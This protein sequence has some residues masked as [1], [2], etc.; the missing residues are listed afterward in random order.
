MIGPDQ[1]IET[2]LKTQQPHALQRRRREIE[3]GGA[4]AGKRRRNPFVADGLPAPVFLFER[5]DG[6]AIDGLQRRAGKLAPQE[7]G[8]KHLMARGHLAPCRPRRSA[9]SPRIST[10]T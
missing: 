6:V 2:V 8:P 4:F 1:P 3:L 7:A 10:L 5:R 9:S